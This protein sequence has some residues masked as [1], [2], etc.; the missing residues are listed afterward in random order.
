MSDTTF[1]PLT[2]ATVATA[3]R[4]DDAAAVRGHA[5]GYAAGR[6]VAERELEARL[7]E[8]EAH[9]ARELA[10]GRARIDAAVA[11]LTDAAEQLARRSAPVLA[12]ADAVLAAAAVELASAILAREPEP[13]SVAVLERALGIA[14]ETPPRRVRL[15]PAAAALVTAPEGVE[16]VADPSVTR[17]SAIIDLARGEID[18]RLEASL[19][20][21]RSALAAEQ[22]VAR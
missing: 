8:L 11:A 12:E 4:D 20:R 17:G 22:G 13:S 21:A 10:E 5:A 1:A 3:D 9:A 6:R 18:A 19:D 16:I 15:D 14:G 7:A 2:F